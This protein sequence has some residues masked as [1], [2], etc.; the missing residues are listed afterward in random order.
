[1]RRSMARLR[2]DQVGGR[3]VPLGMA[4]CKSSSSSGAGRLAFLSWGGRGNGNSFGLATPAPPRSA[5]L[6]F[7]QATELEVGVPG[8]RT[9]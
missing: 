9:P 5:G 4:A 7:P 3:R 1:M 2:C 8:H 6:R